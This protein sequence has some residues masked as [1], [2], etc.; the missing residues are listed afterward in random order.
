MENG[1]HMLVCVIKELVSLCIWPEFVILSFFVSHTYTYTHSTTSFPRFGLVER[2]QSIGALMCVNH[3]LLDLPPMSKSVV[4]NR[5]DN[6]FSKERLHDPFKKKI[7]QKVLNKANCL[8]TTIIMPSSDPWVAATQRSSLGVHEM[9]KR[10]KKKLGFYTVSAEKMFKKESK[11][12]TKETTRDWLCWLL[13]RSTLMPPPTQ[14]QTD[15]DIELIP[16]TGQISTFDDQS[17][18]YNAVIF[19]AIRDGR[20]LGGI[21]H[22]V[23]KAERCNYMCIRTFGCARGACTCILSVFRDHYQWTGLCTPQ[24]SWPH[25]HPQGSCCIPFVYSLQPHSLRR[26]HIRNLSAFL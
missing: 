5:Q 26:T 7:M 4:K 15:T 20:Q 6:K 16:S 14:R 22:A 12:P 10:A 18:F 1:G 21:R 23:S 13:W 24:C 19:P 9:D 2:S 8:M 3:F 25:F 17:R 11:P